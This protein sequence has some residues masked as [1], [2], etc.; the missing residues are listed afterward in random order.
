M[1]DLDAGYRAVDY[2]PHQKEK[3]KKKGKKRESNERG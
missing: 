2:I 1:H 3:R